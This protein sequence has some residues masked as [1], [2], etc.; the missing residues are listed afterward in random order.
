MPP[1]LPLPPR[2]PRRHA[3]APAHPGAPSSRPV[4]RGRRWGIGTG[5]T[6]AQKAALDTELGQLAASIAAHGGPFLLGPQPCTADIL[7]YP[8]ISRFAV[9]APLT[10]YDVAAAGGG[11]IGA[12]LAA[13]ASRPSAAATAA[14][15]ALLLAAFSR[16]HSLDFF[17]F[18]TYRCFQLHPHNAHLLQQP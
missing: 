2:A 12:W 7:V 1:R 9:A 8:F 3:A 6:A 15:P 11:A 13:W 10:G 4:G 18:S 16:E 14:D 5:Q 17:D